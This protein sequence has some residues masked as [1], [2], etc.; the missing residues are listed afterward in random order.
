MTKLKKSPAPQENGGAPADPTPESLDKVR[1][2]L[3]GGQM[4]AVETRLQGLEAKLLRGQETLRTE[5][6][7]QLAALDASLQKEAQILG[8]RLL[9]ERTKR[10]EDLKS[11]AAELKDAL[12]NLEKRHQKLEESSSMADADL[13]E[14]ILQHSKAVSTEISRLSERLT[15]ELTRS[16]QE[17]KAEKA[18]L[19]ALATLFTEMAARLNGEARA[20]AK[21]AA[22]S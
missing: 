20:G 11:L 6:S 15:A 12:R 3:F 7:K 14:G 18:G 19:V 21:G 13:R 16:V 9:A 8:E 5:F 1:D 17:L 10:S 2:I 4:R 22:R